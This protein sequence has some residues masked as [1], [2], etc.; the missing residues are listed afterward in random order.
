MHREENA[1]VKEAVRRLPETLANERQF[2]LARAI[3]QSMKKTL[4]PKEEWLTVETVCVGVT[5]T[6][7]SFTHS[8]TTPQSRW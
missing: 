3:V 5:D 4:L 7:T 8:H 6:H 1:D 2:R